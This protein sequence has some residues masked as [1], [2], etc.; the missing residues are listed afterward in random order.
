MVLELD[1][2]WGGRRA[3]ERRCALTVHVLSLNLIQ[4]VT[5]KKLR[6]LEFKQ[7]F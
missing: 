2:G 4:T 3:R 6:A 1:T 7:G 5:M